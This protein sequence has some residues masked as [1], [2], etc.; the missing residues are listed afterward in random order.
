MILILIEKCSF[1]YTTGC[2][3]DFYL[4]AEGTQQ[5]IY[6]LF[7]CGTK[8]I[9][10]QLPLGCAQRLL[11]LHSRVEKIIQNMKKKNAI[12]SCGVQ[13]ME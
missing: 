5:K 10:L 12:P 11:F 3:G 1:R 2:Q 8:N 4:M 7:D 9:M 6:Y 13:V